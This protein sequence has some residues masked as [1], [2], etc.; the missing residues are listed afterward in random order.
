MRWRDGQIN[1]MNRLPKPSSRVS[2]FVNTVV[3]SLHIRNVLCGG[4]L[5]TSSGHYLQSQHHGDPP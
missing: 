3:A 4:G 1:E 2:N 5:P